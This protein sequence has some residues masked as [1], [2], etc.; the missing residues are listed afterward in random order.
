M[1][2]S[3]AMSEEVE[4]QLRDHLL[5]GD[6][7]EDLCFALWRP[8]QG[9]T[10]TTALVFKVLL[11][12]P[13]DRLVH[14][15]ASFKPQFV[16]RA[17][18]EALAAGAGVALLHAHPR[19]RGWQGLSRP[20]RVAERRL[21]PPVKAMTD[22]PLLGLTLAGDGGWSARAW[23]RRGPR[24]YTSEQCVSVR[25]V[26]YR[27]QVHFNDTLVPPPPH[28]ESQARTRSAWG[29]KAQSHLTRLRVGVVG[30]GSVGSIVAEGLAR[31][32]VQNIVLLDHQLFEEVNLDRTLNGH[33][34]DVGHPKVD[35]AA[36]AL[37][38]SATTAGFTVAPHQLSICEPE[39]FSAALD[40]DV[41]FCCV[42]R[43]WARKVLNQLAFAHLIPVIDGG[44][45]VRRTSSGLLNSADW[46]AH[47]VAPGYRCLLCLGQYEPADV[48]TEMRGDLDDPH[49]IAS[50]P[51]EHPLRANENVFGFGLATASLELL[52]FLLLVVGPH[53]VGSV[54][55]QNYH[56]LTGHIDLT[57]EGCKP[58]CI[59]AD[60][61]AAGSTVH[62]GTGAHPA[63]EK[64]RQAWADSPLRG[65][66]R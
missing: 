43:P 6:R 19:G 53:G 9:A 30:L 64:E 10:R 45:H 21:A 49:Y 46:K 31:T 27:L 18:D 56:L 44:I 65:H 52:H 13:G 39:G 35:L 34:S 1:N 37:P 2:W 3:V 62:P 40:C 20:D 36:R 55:S 16:E 50:L 38:E 29:P 24:S 15:N 58:D 32:G 8:S 33:T 57:T 4:A 7:Q 66:S 28:R 11:P 61:I 60:R 47:V 63:A 14:G 48:A 42:D 51:H 59:F 22:L 54:G 17:L 41:L 5:R 23:D 26:G 12:G 25:V